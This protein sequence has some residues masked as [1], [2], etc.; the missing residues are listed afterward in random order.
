MQ[1]LFF[2]FF[3]VQMTYCCI[4]TFYCYSFYEIENP[5]K[6]NMNQKVWKHMLLFKII[7]LTKDSE[8]NRNH[9]VHAKQI[10]TKPPLASLVKGPISHLPVTTGKRWYKSPLYIHRWQDLV[11]STNLLP[12]LPSILEVL[13]QCNKR[14]TKLPIATN[15]AE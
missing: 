10:W 1:P 13:K 7:H 4:S 9:I 5:Q 3:L 6:K 2:F 14:E 12:R 11:G 15:I 8:W